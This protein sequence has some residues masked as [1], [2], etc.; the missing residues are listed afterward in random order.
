[1]LHP[2][3]QA[4]GTSPAESSSEHRVHHQIDPG[5]RSAQGLYLHA[6]G[7]GPS[8]GPPGSAG[9]RLSQLVHL[10]RRS[11]PPQEPGGHVT[12]SSVVSR[13]GQNGHPAPVSRPHP[14]RGDLHRPAGPLHQHFHRLGAHPVQA[15]SL[16]GGDDRLHLRVL[17]GQ[18]DHIVGKLSAPP[19]P[20]P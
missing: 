1:M 11:P 4:R 14:G 5:G 13:P 6:G 8:Q 9:L 2:G 17:R 10:H 15:G 3:R 7:H 18:A 20:G 16:G 12:I 19:R